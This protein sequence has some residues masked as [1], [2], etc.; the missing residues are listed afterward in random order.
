MPS[1][2]CCCDL[3]CT[4]A[5]PCLEARDVDVD[6]S[7]IANAD[8]S[9][10]TDLN[11]TYILSY[12]TGVASHPSCCWSQLISPPQTGLGC[13]PGTTGGYTVGFTLGVP[14]TGTW[15]MKAYVNIIR[16]VGGSPVRTSMVWGTTDRQLMFKFCSGQ[17]IQLPYEGLVNGITFSDYPESCSSTE[18][19]PSGTNECDGTSSTCYVQRV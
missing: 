10:C 4:L 5:D 14:T 11:S 19:S 17:R 2:G 1:P 12:A 6:L 16:N 13:T 3:N 9:H 7:G 18:G 15:R 8:C